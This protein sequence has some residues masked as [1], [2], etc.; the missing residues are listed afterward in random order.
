MATK[1]KIIKENWDLGEGRIPKIGDYIYIED[2]RP[3]IMSGV[4]VAIGPNDEELGSFELYG[5]MTDKDKENF[6]EFKKIKREQEKQVELQ[7][8]NTQLKEA[9][10]IVKKS[11]P[12]KKK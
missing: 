6:E 4:A 5:I 12:I 1:L 10:T 8:T 7:E 2:I 3:Y 9:L 11:A